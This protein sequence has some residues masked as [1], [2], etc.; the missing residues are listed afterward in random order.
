MSTAPVDW[1]REG[2]GNRAGNPDGANDWH[3]LI[4]SGTLLAI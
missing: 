2:V 4:D 1:A 3:K